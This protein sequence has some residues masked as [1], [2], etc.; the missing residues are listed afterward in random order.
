MSI[1]S[2][3]FPQSK[4]FCINNSWCHVVGVVE[5]G[6]SLSGLAELGSFETEMVVSA[7]FDRSCLLAWTCQDLRFGGSR[8][9]LFTIIL[10]RVWEVGKKA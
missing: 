10:S 4:P 6:I 1:S 9:I 8:S 2:S 5:F 3:S 7:L